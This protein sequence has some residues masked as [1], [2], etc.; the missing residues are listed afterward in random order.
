MCQES[1]LLGHCRLMQLSGVITMGDETILLAVV[2]E[3]ANGGSNTRFGTDNQPKGRGR[4]RGS[5]N[6][7]SPAF[8]RMLLEVAKELGSVALQRLG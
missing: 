3:R 5:R 1:L 2:P 6:K 7:M 8:K 4:P